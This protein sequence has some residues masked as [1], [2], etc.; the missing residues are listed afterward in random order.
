MYLLNRK[1]LLCRRIKNLKPH[2]VQDT[3]SVNNVRTKIINMRKPI[4]LITDTITK[5]IGVCGRP[6]KKIHE[7]TGDIKELEKEYSTYG[8]YI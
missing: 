4:A 3:I 2:L 5:E 8:Y 1:T 6:E 7:F